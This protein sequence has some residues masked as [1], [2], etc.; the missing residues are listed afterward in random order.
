MDRCAE[1]ETYG[2]CACRQMAVYVLACMGWALPLAVQFM[3][4][5]AA[6]RRFYS[7][8]ALVLNC[9]LDP[10]L[11]SSCWAGANGWAASGT[12][13]C[14][15]HC[16]RPRCE[17]CATAKGTDL[18]LLGGSAVLLFAGF[19]AVAWQ[20]AGSIFV[21]RASAMPMCDATHMHALGS[22]L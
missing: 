6:Q 5:S 7:R 20:L 16:R 12:V 4:E 1:D 17:S 14:C 15:R 3:T 8:C 19:C 18:V 2:P 22:R 9:Q 11:P 13:H 10:L 21:P